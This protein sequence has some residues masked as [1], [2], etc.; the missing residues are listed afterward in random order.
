MKKLIE[1]FP[2]LFCFINQKNFLKSINN[3]ADIVNYMRLDFLKLVDSIYPYKHIDDKYFINV[4][5]LA[6][7]YCYVYNKAYKYDNIRFLLIKHYKEF[8][9]IDENYIFEYKHLISYLDE[10]ILV[11]LTL[12]YLNKNSKYEISLY[13]KEINKQCKSEDLKAKINAIISL[14]GALL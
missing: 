8:L 11:N 5:I 3:E 1:R 10:E 7:Q 2:F 12:N 14:K 13:L 9:K 6:M 4:L